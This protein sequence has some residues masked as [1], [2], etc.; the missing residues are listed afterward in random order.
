MKN[1]HRLFHLLCAVV[2]IAFIAG[3]GEKIADSKAVPEKLISGLKDLHGKKVASLTGS[4]FVE[5]ARQ[6]APDVELIP[7]YFNDNIS[8][9]ILRIT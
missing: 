6:T 3:C 8:R 2:T 9:K 4:C 7:V 1:I 5:K